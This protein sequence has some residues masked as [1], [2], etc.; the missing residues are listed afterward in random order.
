M[1]KI[2]KKSFNKAKII[3]SVTRHFPEL[4]E[5]YGAVYIDQAVDKYFGNV[6]ENEVRAGD[7]GEQIDITPVLEFI[8]AVIGLVVMLLSIRKE[9]TDVKRKSKDIKIEYKVEERIDSYIDTIPG[10]IRSEVLSVVSKEK[11]S[12]ILS[13][14]NFE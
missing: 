4:V 2:S 13:E 5:D 9:I 1:N 7:A 11:I 14:D 3:S 6:Y 8:T 12:V 10:N